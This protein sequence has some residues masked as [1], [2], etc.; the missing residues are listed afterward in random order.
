MMQKGF[1]GKKGQQII[2]GL[3]MMGLAAIIYAVFLPVMNGFLD[4]AIANATTRGETSQALLISLVP[5]L[6]W[7]VIVIGFLGVVAFG[8]Q[9]QQ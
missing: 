8:S 6:G 2:I 3:V 1:V 5:L 7:F 4:I 9:G